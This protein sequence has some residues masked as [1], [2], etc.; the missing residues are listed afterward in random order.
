M[1]LPI[2]VPQQLNVQP[3]PVEKVA[4]TPKPEPGKNDVNYS[5]LEFK[6]QRAAKERAIDSDKAEKKKKKDTYERDGADSENKKG[7]KS[8]KSKDNKQDN[9]EKKLNQ[10]DGKGNILDV[11]G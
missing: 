10:N 8:V 6:D 11:V 7:Q 4:Q 2:E 9:R 1:S 5:S 3:I